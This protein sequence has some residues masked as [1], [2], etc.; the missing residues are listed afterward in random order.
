MEHQTPINK[1]SYNYGQLHIHVG[2]MYA[3]KTTR[4]IEKYYEYIHLYEHVIVLTHSS[5]NRYSVE[6]L[7]THDKTKIPCVKFNSIS[8][9]IE[10]NHEQLTDIQV[11]LI[12][13]SQFFPDLDKVLY[14]VDCLHKKIH[15]FGL[16]GDYNRNKFGMITDLIP[17]CDSVEKLTATCVRCN[18][19][20]IFSHRTVSCKDQ[21]LVGSNDAYE[22]LCRNCYNTAS[23]EK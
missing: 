7:S 6:Q 19:P 1:M 23:N 10:K 2:P 16:D 15:L 12:D 13:E 9:F 22:S 14:L 21:I 18:H 4:L 17:Y 5:E 11:I 3:K 8:E 20:A